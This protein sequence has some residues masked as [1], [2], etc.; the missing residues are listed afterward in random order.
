[1][2]NLRNPISSVNGLS[3]TFL[4]LFN[5]SLA[6]KLDGECIYI[7]SDMFQMLEEKLM[8]LVDELV[9]S[10]NKALKFSNNQLVVML[11]TNGG[12]LH[13]V[14]RLVRI[15]RK[16]YQKVSFVIPNFAYSAATV[17]ALSGDRIY[18]NYFSVLGPIDPQIQGPSGRYYSGQGLLSKYN[19]ALKKINDA[20][21]INSVQAEVYVLTKN[22]EQAELFFV[23]QAVLHGINLVT[24]WL[25]K[26]KFKNW[27]VT[28]TKKNK[29]TSSM[30]KSRAET[31]AGILG[32]AEMWHSH[33]RGIT[34]ERLEM[35]DIKLKIDDFGA[36]SELNDFVIQYH[37]LANSYFRNYEIKNVIHSRL[38]VLEV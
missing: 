30:R 7:K 9:K 28:E 21:D 26:Y 31:I 5:S 33:G 18:M 15:M 29:V 35:D 19:Q 22:F 27:K 37:N 10:H 11:E 32:N 36:I 24:E 4:G 23:E 34:R 17:L 20:E 6:E 16:N 14:E 12:S 8:N 2:D 13:T 38:G 1:M 25:V 3:D